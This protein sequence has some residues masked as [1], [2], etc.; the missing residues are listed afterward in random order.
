MDQEVLSKFNPIFLREWRKARGLTL[1]ELGK[2]AGVDHGNL[3]KLERGI[4][5]YSQVLLEKLADALGVTPAILLAFSPDEVT[6]VQAE[7]S[8]SDGQDMPLTQAAWL[9][10][11]KYHKFS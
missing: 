2:L 1:I 11:C 5:P 10:I 7:I 6:D 3:S 9:K 8:G 4:F